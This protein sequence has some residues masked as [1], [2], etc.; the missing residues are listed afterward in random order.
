[1]KILIV[2]DEA[3]AARR[4]ERL[5]REFFGDQA[6]SVVCKTT[7]QGSE[8]YLG[9]TV[10]DLLLLDLNLNG[11]DGFKLLQEAV[12]GRFQTIIVSAN[13]DRALTAFEY[14][15]QDFVPK[16][17]DRERLFK[18]LERLRSRI[19]REESPAK[20]FAVR[21]YGEVEL[22]PMEE[23]LFLQGAD[24]Y[25]EIHCQNGS[26]HLHSKTLEAM[27]SILPSRF[28]RIH[29]SYIVDRDHICRVHLHGAG[30]Y[31]IELKNGQRLPLSRSRY[32]ELSDILSH[33]T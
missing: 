29:K 30:K 5:V 17:V 25:A 31:E 12:A 26:V 7:L 4:L 2:E 10:V 24:D 3:V 6:E 28:I 20:V 11:E 22:I 18:A 16:P 32:K 27:E 8:D 9:E 15:V 13:T 14:G 19:S 23:V 21:K 1:M 33:L